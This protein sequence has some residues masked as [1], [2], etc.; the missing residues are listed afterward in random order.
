MKSL[1]SVGNDGSFPEGYSYS[2]L[3]TDYLYKALLAMQASGD[4]RMM[5]Y[6]FVNNY[7]NWLTHMVMPGGYVDNAYDCGT[8]KLPSY[9]AAPLIK[10][11]LLLNDATSKWFVNNF[12]NGLPLYNKGDYD[13]LY[14]YRTLNS[15]LGSYQPASYRYFSDGRTLTW[16]S[17]WNNSNTVGLWLK[18]GNSSEHSH[19]HWDK[20]HISVYYGN[21]PLLIEAG[22][23][24][25]SD[26]LLSTY[27]QPLAGH[28]VLQATPKSSAVSD[29]PITVNGLDATS[30]NV[31]IDGRNA[32]TNVTRWNRSIVWSNSIAFSLNITD[33]AQLT[34]IKNIGDEWFRFHTGDALTTDLIVQGSDYSWTVTINNNVTMQFSSNKKISIQIVQLPDASTDAKTHACIVVKGAES[35]SSLNLATNLTILP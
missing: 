35:S 2:I 30:G 22:T 27:Y 13:L 23:P 25:Y 1:D 14:Y 4:T 28:N 18:G 26:P 32:Y 24:V 20:G 34:T 19:N 16:R 7:T 3:A 10:S 6:G 11:S 5:S 17:G 9:I 21:S 15:S 33:D 29:V 8:Y 31:T 12:Y